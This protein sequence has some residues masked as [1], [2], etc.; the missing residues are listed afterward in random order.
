MNNFDLENE[1]KNVYFFLTEKTLN[2]INFKKVNARRTNELTSIYFLFNKLRLRGKNKFIKIPKIDE[3]CF[4]LSLVLKK[5]KITLKLKIKN[6]D[7]YY[8]VKENF[9]EDNKKLQKLISVDLKKI[10]FDF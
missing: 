4:L 1:I 6:D 9:V 8:L 10:G 3:I 5:I 2:K 7:Y